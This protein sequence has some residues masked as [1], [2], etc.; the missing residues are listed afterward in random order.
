MKSHLQEFARWV[1]RLQQLMSAIVVVLFTVMMGVVLLQIG[2]R[3]LLSYATA[4][5][6]ELS[7]F[8]Q[9]WLVLLGAGVAMA[10]NQHMAIDLLPAMLPLRYARIASI[11]IALVVLLFLGMMA[12]GSIPL[13]RLGT[14]Q[15]SPAMGVPLWLVYACLP[16]GAA[17]IALELVVS[18]VRRWDNPFAAPEIVDVEVA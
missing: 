12:Y 3:Y 8:C 10:R 4:W 18:V 5:A 15:S 17:Y 16:I 6:T 13:V 11:L 7:T 14:V 2:S 1:N 9:V